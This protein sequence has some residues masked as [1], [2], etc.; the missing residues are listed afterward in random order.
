MN[1]E[2]AAN[3]DREQVKN[4]LVFFVFGI[5][6]MLLWEILSAAATDVLAGSSIP[7]STA[8]L[9]LGISDML[10]KLT[11]PWVF[12]KI[13]YNVKMFIIVFLDIL[14]LI[15][16]VVSESIVVRLVGFAVVDIAKSTLEI[17]TLSMLAFYKKGAIEGFAGGYGVGNILGALYYT[18]MV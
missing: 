5:Y 18:G 9:P 15:T 16:I 10:V 12:Q 17:M 7:T 4:I 13:S 1:A 6:M 8:M 11:L 2:R 14:G 3:D